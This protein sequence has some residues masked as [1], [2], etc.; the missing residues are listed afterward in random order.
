M[1]WP[2]TPIEHLSGFQPSFCPRR[3]CP[4]H[5][6][7]RPGF[8]F[9]RLGYY[10]TN[11]RRRIPRF[12]CLACGESFSRQSFAVSYYRKRPELL[13]PVAAGLVAGSAHRQLARTLGC[14]PSTVTRI[15]SRL[16]RHAIL[17]LAQ[18]RFDLLGTV[19]EPFVLDHFET[20]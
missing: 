18:A 11:R 15:A 9:R 6:R 8:R 14:A 20:F 17:L 7:R 13:L 2:A 3:A 4:E 12:V 10:S 16:G 1:H 19:E 5:L